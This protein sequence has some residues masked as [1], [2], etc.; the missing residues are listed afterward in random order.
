[1]PSLDFCLDKLSYGS[2]A[3]KWDLSVFLYK[4]AVLENRKTVYKSIEANRYGD[5]L[6]ERVEL[7]SNLFEYFNSIITSG[8]S[9]STVITQ[10]ERFSNFMRWCELENKYISKEHI[11]ENCI[12]W[13]NSDILRVKEE[14]LNEH[15]A[16]KGYCSVARIITL[17]QPLQDYPNSKSLMLRT[18]IKAKPQ[19][20]ETMLVSESDVFAFGQLLKTLVEQLTIEAVR[21]ELPLL[22]KLPNGNEVYLKG[23]MKVVDLDCQKMSSADIKHAIERRRALNKDESLLDR[24]RR[25][26]LLNIRIEADLLIFISQTNMNLSQ[27]LDL[28]LTDFRWKTQDDEYL[29]YSVTVYKNRKNGE[30]SFKC[31][32]A[33]RAI[34][35]NYIQWLRKVGFNDDSYLF[36]FV[37]REKIKAD[38]SSR[39]LHVIRNF[40]KTINFEYVSPLQLRKFKANWLFDNA[41]D[42]SA[43]LSLMSHENTTFR[44]HY[45]KT[46]EK[47]ALKQL[48]HFNSQN[49]IKIAIGLCSNNCQNP[50]KIKSEER[51]ALPDCVNPEG[52]LFCVHHKDILSYD[53]CYKLVSHLYLKRLE[54]ALNP[55]FIQ[56]SPAILIEP[57][58]DCRRPKTLRQCPYEKQTI[59]N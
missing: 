51:T 29:A 18:N 16:Y 38:V 15:Q 32:K 25:S 47:E 22:I 27:A 31:Y 20:K 53:Y 12:A 4:N 54:I 2:H 10:L 11:A 42:A 36:P 43:V 19:Q 46:N 56:N 6:T 28:K 8:A 9:Q 30:A 58:R 24:Y 57:S 55:S 1:M 3:Y 59:L 33:Y 34:F 26:N 49:L 21:G 17:S 35:D 44:R 13:V 41:D 39:K 40:C 45:Q 5:I 23:N 37:G 7:I 52:C 14:K 48:G 50:Q